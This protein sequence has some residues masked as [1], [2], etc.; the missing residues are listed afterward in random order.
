MLFRSCLLLCLFCLSTGATETVSVVKV[1]NFR[2][3]HSQSRNKKKLC[4]C[5]LMLIVFS[6][7]FPLTAKPKSFK[8]RRRK[9]KTNVRIYKR[10]ELMKSNRRIKNTL[11]SFVES[12]YHKISYYKKLNLRYLC[13]DPR[14]FRY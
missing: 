3:F 1:I 4:F 13:S 8:L 6:K 12:I 5:V 11:N 14:Q 7:I 2:I 10:T 9:T